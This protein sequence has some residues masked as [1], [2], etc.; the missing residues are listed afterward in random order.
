MIFLITC[1]IYKT[2]CQEKVKT[3]TTEIK[4]NWIHEWVCNTIAVPNPTRY[5]K[6][7][8]YEAKTQN[9]RLVRNWSEMRIS[10]ILLHMNLPDSHTVGPRS[11]LQLNIEQ[12]PP[13]KRM[14]VRSASL[15]GAWWKLLPPRNYAKSA[16]RTNFRPISI[17]RLLQYICHF[18]ILGWIC[19]TYDITNAFVNCEIDRLF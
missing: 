16:F 2:C 18:C 3:S 5:T 14:Q 10:H 8:K 7:D 12:D 15:C 17:C 9:S 11:D 4:K 1:H 13:V 19:N 6:F